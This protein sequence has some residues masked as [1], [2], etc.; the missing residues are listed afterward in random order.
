MSDKKA[1]ENKRRKKKILSIKF[2]A[3]KESEKK[4]RLS[5]WRIR[6]R[7]EISPIE[8]NKIDKLILLE[9]KNN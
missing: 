7:V 2:K 1:K 9:N 5:P 4:M 8:I 3:G 6:L